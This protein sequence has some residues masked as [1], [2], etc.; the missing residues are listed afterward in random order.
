MK[1]LRICLYR[2]VRVITM[3]DKNFDLREDPKEGVSIA[4]ITEVSV[5]TLS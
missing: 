4:G 2:K 3:I 5:S 1:I